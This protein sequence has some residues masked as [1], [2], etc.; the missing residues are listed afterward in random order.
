MPQPLV[1]SERDELND[2]TGH[3]HD[4]AEASA[5]MCLFY[6]GFTKFPLG[7]YTATEREALERSIPGPYEQGASPVEMDA[8]IKNRYGLTWHTPAAGS[9]KATLLETPGLAVSIGGYISTPTYSGGHRICF[10]TTPKL[11]LNPLAANKS[12]G[13]ATTVAAMLTFAQ[14]RDV[15]DLRYVHEDQYLASTA[16]GTTIDMP[17]LTVTLPANP[18]AGSLAIPAGTDSIRVSD[19]SHYKVPSAATRAAYTA[20]LTGAVSG[21]GYLVD[22]D[23][24]EL[25]FIRKAE[26]G[27]AFTASATG[28]SKH[29]VTVAVDGQTKATVTV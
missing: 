4:C 22:L 2:P 9:S 10:L 3:L 13:V 15:T 27:I 11:E 21:P 7:L 19:G 29:T 18:T 17:G 20:E 14:G 1:W 6:G 12:G 16:G 24:D 25:H 23:G 8:A 26:S 28:D 5:L